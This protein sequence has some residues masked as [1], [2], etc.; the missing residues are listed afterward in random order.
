[1]LDS[2]RE[3]S[4]TG[5]WAWLTAPIEPS[6]SQANPATVCWRDRWVDPDLV[7]LAS[8]RAPLT[9][10]EIHPDDT[11]PGWTLPVTNVLPAPLA[12]HLDRPLVAGLVVRDRHAHPWVA[13]YAARTVTVF[14]RV[15]AAT[16][17]ARPP[18][19]WVGDRLVVL[20]PSPPTSTPLAHGN[21]VALEATGPGYVKF[22]P[23][24]SELAAV[25]AARPAA[26][27]P[28]A[29]QAIGLTD[30]LVV[31]R[32][33]ALDGEL[34]VEYA[35][36][37]PASE[38]GLSWSGLTVPMDGS[39][40]PRRA[41]K[42]HHRL[43]RGAPP[44]RT[45]PAPEIT[46][47]MSITIDTGHHQARL[48]QHGEGPV[49]VLWLR[50][51]RPTGTVT[52]PPLLDTGYGVANLDLPL[53]WPPDATVE[54]LHPQIVGAVRAALATIDGPVLVGGHSFSATL[55]LYALA[56]IPELRGAIAHS[57]CYN[58]TLTPTGWQHEKR[59]LWQ[60][61]EIY[62]A[63]SA[64]EFAH[65]LNRPV[66]LA[67]GTK[68]SNPATTPE[69]SVELYRAIVA[70]GG[71]ARL[72]LLPGAGHAFYYAEHLAFLRTEHRNW[73]MRWTR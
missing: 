31:R 42:T 41:T 16:S 2:W 45:A 35:E 49:A 37:D 5:P 30:P 58:R 17:L 28:P 59:H 38:D 4:T 72:L 27:D 61:P 65:Q 36:D 23:T 39:G 67:H 26:L 68:D 32:L 9:R 22:Q 69:Q 52:L 48:T 44:G 47:P 3:S 53:H 66:L 19:V 63:F 20:I 55:A 33:T 64:L 25:V 11:S 62:R 1:M 57:G 24:L 54:S 15:R 14:D 10:I 56:H 43:P 73:I 40:P 51:T 50:D 6:I 34:H 60:A 21:P 29:G 7:G 70:N 8:D 12:W 46:S 18:L 71:T 13:D